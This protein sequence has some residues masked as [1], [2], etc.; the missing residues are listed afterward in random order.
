MIL[1]L[2]I[3]RGDIGGDR[4]LIGGLEL[5][6]SSSVKSVVKFKHNYAFRIQSLQNI[7][8]K[9]TIFGMFYGILFAYACCFV[10]VYN[11]VKLRVLHVYGI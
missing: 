8:N 4:G 9:I 11:Y 3:R 6:P 2:R 5:Q 10:M 7:R 1:D